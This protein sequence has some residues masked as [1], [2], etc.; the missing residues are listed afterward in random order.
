M[1]VN[2]DIPVVD[3]NPAAVFPE[4]L[5]RGLAQDD[6]PLADGHGPFLRFRETF[7]DEEMG[8]QVQGL[9]LGNGFSSGMGRDEAAGHFTFVDDP[10]LGRDGKG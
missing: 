1:S 4:L 3:D 5:R 7:A 9:P 2:P 10:D 8:G 6:V